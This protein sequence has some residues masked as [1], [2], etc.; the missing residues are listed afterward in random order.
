K[1]QLLESLFLLGQLCTLIPLIIWQSRLI[2]DGKY[3]F[4]RF[5][6]LNI[7][8]FDR[9]WF[10]SAPLIVISLVALNILVNLALFLIAVIQNRSI[11]EVLHLKLNNEYSSPSTI[12]IFWRYISLL[13]VLG[14][15]FSPT[16]VFLIVTII[17][18][19]YQK[20]KEEYKEA[21][22]GHIMA[23]YI[24]SKDYNIKKLA[25]STNVPVSKIIPLVGQ[26]IILDYSS[27]FGEYNIQKISKVVCLSTEELIKI[28]GKDLLM[29]YV[30]ATRE[31]NIEK[32]SEM[33]GLPKSVIIDIIGEELILHYIQEANDYNIASIAQQ[34]GLPYTMASKYYELLKHKNKL[35]QGESHQDQGSI[36]YSQINK[37]KG[38]IKIYGEVEVS[39][40]S[41]LLRMSESRLVDLLLE[42]IGSG[43]LKLTI[44][45][46]KIRPQSDVNIDD[47][48]SSLDTAFSSWIENEKS[49][50][51]KV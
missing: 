30:M 47:V 44:E 46:G 18:R 2:G 3:Y 41:E 36:K 22:K 7:K 23:K 25:D 21:L 34:T 42:F 19:N 24:E 26:H 35:R 37:L 51:E 6:I 9:L 27:S 1:N 39:K 50:S 12:S 17:I 5:Y 13:L 14:G 11:V 29:A 15:F 20:W 32:I 45:D 10:E 4:D 49:K 31:Y 40:A 43:D 16:L 28:A 38:L 33:L 48:L 8:I